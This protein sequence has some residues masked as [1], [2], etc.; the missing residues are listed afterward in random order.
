MFDPITDTAMAS[1]K[2]LQTI[3]DVSSNLYTNTK[4]SSLIDFTSAARVEPICIV[5]SDCVH[6]E[7]LPEVLQ[8][9]QSIFTGYYL[10]AVSL[11]T[12]LGD[13]K[14]IKQLE[15]LNPN[16]SSDVKQ[17]LIDEAK[18]YYDKNGFETGAPT[19]EVDWRL[20][21]ES[22]RYS[23]PTTKNVHS[24]MSG[25]AMEAAA[26]TGS[27]GGKGGKGGKTQIVNNNFRS[28]GGD[29]D[30]NKKEDHVETVDYK[31]LDVAKEITNLSVGK[32]INVNLKGPEG[33]QAT[34]PIAIRLMVTLMD[35][36]NL[37]RILTISAD[38]HSVTERYHAWRSGRI[39]FVKDLILCMDLIAE[40]KK[41][42]ML[43]KS[44]VY[45]EIM[46]RV[47]N[48]KK[49][50]FM[51]KNPSINNAS[52]LIVMSQNTVL[53]VEDRLG[54]G[55]ISNFNT[56]QKLFETTYAMIIA[57]IDTEWEKVTFYHRGISTATTLG[58]RDIKQHG[59][60][61]GPDVTDILKAFTQGSAPNL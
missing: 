21:S 50:G 34:I 1:G 29:K 40:H 17:Y 41:G 56:R 3:K 4:T 38:D 5:A 33:Q 12:Q 47:N 26:F 9:M 45:A 15:R 55:K 61:N 48:N 6:I 22:Y 53:D 60:G 20:R 13:V 36:A 23:L 2:V 10:Q 19:L 46:N 43:D 57:V 28:G 27:A 54:G 35:K 18:N 44:G 30:G 58:L 49:A 11:L 14:V 37:A 24:V 16:R 39:S 8:C 59:K 32:L 51:D 42:L 7:Y 25:L 31:G 52:T